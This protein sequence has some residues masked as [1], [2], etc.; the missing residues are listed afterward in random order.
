[1]KEESS[2][3]LTGSFKAKTLPFEVYKYSTTSPLELRPNPVFL[4][5]SAVSPGFV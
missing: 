4:W 5:L 1:M 2:F 3:P